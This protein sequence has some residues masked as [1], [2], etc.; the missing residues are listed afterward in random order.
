LDKRAPYEIKFINLGELP[1]RREFGLLRLQHIWGPMALT[2]HLKAKTIGAATF[3]GELT[4]TIT[5]LFESFDLLEK[6]RKI[7][8]QV[9]ESHNYNTTS[10]KREDY[11]KPTM[12]ALTSASVRQSI[13]DYLNPN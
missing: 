13:K 9:C 5:G 12:V 10:E 8:E 6:V 7:L 11:A 1:F 4:L 3:N 2:P